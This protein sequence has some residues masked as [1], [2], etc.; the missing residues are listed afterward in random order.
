M[1]KAPLA[2]TQ[3]PVVAPPQELHVPESELMVACAAGWLHVV[4]RLI[5]T[6]VDANYV[7]EQGEMPLTY[8]ATWGHESVVACLLA[9]GAKVDGP[10]EPAWSPL[11]YAASR[12]NRRVVLALLINGAD[13]QRR[14]KNGRTAA[15]LA[16]N[17]GHMDCVAL[18]KSWGRAE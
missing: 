5:A 11:M 12:G 18:M 13:P 16:R 7:S 4:R 17:A 8:A 14:D 15:D 10:T 3:N 9:K 6:G 2:P 1:Q